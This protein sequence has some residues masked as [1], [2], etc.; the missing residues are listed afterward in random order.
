MFW[1]QLVIAA[2]SGQLDRRGEAA[3]AVRDLLALDPGFAAHARRDIEVWHFASGLLEPILE[4]VRRGGLT[5]PES[6]SSPSIPVSSSPSEAGR[7]ARPSSGVIR[8]RA[9][10]GFWVAVLPFKYRGT[11]R[12]LEALAED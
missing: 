2:I 11:D 1:Q 10:E 8:A 5:V 7:G 12:D 4:G 3:S 9:D 6:S